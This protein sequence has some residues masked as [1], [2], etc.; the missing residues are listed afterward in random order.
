M[1]DNTKNIIFSIELLIV[2][3]GM[4]IYML[5]KSPQDYS[6]SERRVLKQ[7]PTIS[8]ENILSGAYMTN[9]ENY[10]LDQFPFRDSF[11][12]Y[13]ALSSKYLFL[14]KDNNK[15]FEINGY[16]SKLEYPLN[17]PMLDHAIEKFKY[18]NDNYLTENEKQ[19]YLI[20][21]PDKN[22]YLLQEN[23]FLSMN[24]DELY[25]YMYSN[26]SYMKPIDIRNDL[27]IEDYY[28][29]DTHWRQNNLLKIKN[30]IL[31]EVSQDKLDLQDSKNLVFDDVNNNKEYKE[32][33][34]DI[35]FKGVY[36]GQSALPLKPDTIT[37]LTNE[38]IENAIVYNYDT[39]KQKE[40]KVYNLDKAN[41]KDA[42]E[43]FLDG[44]TAII[45]I[46]N[47]KINSNRELIMFRD[48]FGSSLAPLF[49]EEY[50]KIILVDIRYV[51][52]NMLPVFITKKEFNNSDIIF[53]Y[54]TILLNNSLGL[55]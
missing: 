42:Y 21:V 23:N 3:M 52:S 26:T 11:R 43:M 24:Y 41:G 5:L 36:F 46:E 7:K 13:K 28:Y 32:I 27:S 22:Y 19:P 54:S 55:K 18:I 14:K 1:K 47:P 30:K 10:T 16:V 51:Q 48:S 35:P 15:V 39:G 49:I 53:E 33:I 37:Y 4:M 25:N 12:S 20:I 38:E 50:S 45:T 2:L 6:D 34:L 9:F 31:N 17:T 44:A 29:T 8:L 40:S